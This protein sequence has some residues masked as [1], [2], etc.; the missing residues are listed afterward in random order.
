[1]KNLFKIMMLFVFVTY[2]ANA[3]AQINIA[4]VQVAPSL[5]EPLE[6]N[7]EGKV[8]FR[9]Y[10]SNGDDVL[11]TIIGEPNTR[12]AIDFNKAKL[13]ADSIANVLG[14]VSNYFTITVKNDGKTVNLVQKATI[15]ASTNML[16]TVLFEVTENAEAPT[17][18]KVGALVNIDATDLSSGDGSFYVYTKAY[19]P[20]APEVTKVD[21]KDT[22][23]DTP[24][25]V[26]TPDTTP[27]MTGTCEVGTTVAVQI[28][29]ED[30]TPTTT[31]K[32]DGTFE[33]VPDEELA[34]GEYKI[35]STQEKNG[36]YIHLR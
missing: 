28:D 31:C 24:K 11:G 35:T 4:Q 27:T 3:Y 9:L 17:T 8:T 22:E 25:T 16:V 7:G 30:I 19:I 2:V 14:D 29:D 21:G 34:E 18:N 23:G 12:I 15:P 20:G 1:M 10:E 26:T 6:K 36:H 32:E 33:I 13:K 5:L